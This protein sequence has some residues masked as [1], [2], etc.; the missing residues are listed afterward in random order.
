MK[1]KAKELD[2]KFDAGESIVTDLELT[3][4]RRPGHDQRRVDDEV[5]AALHDYDAATRAGDIDGQVA[6]FAEAWRSSSGT[7]KAELREQLEQQGDRSGDAEKR[8]VPR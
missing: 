7:T 1:A 5:L 3:K 2:R 6:F 4:A 8:F